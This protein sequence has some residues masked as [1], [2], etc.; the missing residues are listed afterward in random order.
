MFTG[1]FRVDAGRFPGI[2][3]AIAYITILG[4]GY[5]MMYPLLTLILEEQGVSGTL[6]GVSTMAQ[7][8][9]AIAITP[10]LPRILRRIGLPALMV[11][12]AALEVGTFLCLFL[13]QDVWIWMPFRA[14]L[15]MSGSI[16]FY[17]SEYW[18]VAMAPNARRGRVVGTYAFFVAASF[19]I[20]PLFLTVI[21]F[22][23]FL[24]FAIP[25]LLCAAGMVPVILARHQAPRFSGEG[26]L[27]E[28]PKFFL[29]NPTICLA[30]VLF[31]AL[32]A[33]L[34]GLFPAWGVR[35][36]LGPEAAVTL[37]GIAGFGTVFIQ[38]LMGPA[39][40]RVNRR[41]LMGLCAAT[42]AALMLVMPSLVDGRLALW[43]AVFAWGGIAAGLYTV[44][45]V[46]LGARYEGKVLA[47]GNAALIMGYS[48]G[49]A[50]GP[51]AAGKMM[52]A[53]PPHGM[54]Y[55]L[56]AGCVL[57]VALLAYRG[58]TVRHPVN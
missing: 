54:L 11:L 2:A 27:S 26:S 6:I 35:S 40:D 24:P 19:G 28:V 8:A 12:S 17:G 58:V 45:L 37:I 5:G 31:G 57:F 46:E 38:P 48:I 25:M 33:G 10:F 47:V 52:D 1:A 49:A 18:I 36:G 39:A 4:L 42:C 30:V 23:G 7:A 43:A 15:G 50:V 3:A 41:W 29:G 44:A 55:S 20:G 56:S 32:E 21:G 22:E 13:K 14:I 51:P 34:L 16:A 53:I 9:G